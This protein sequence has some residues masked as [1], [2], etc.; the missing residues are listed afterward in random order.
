MGFLGRNGIS[1]TICKQSAPRSKQITTPTLHH[2]IFYKPDPL[3][4][5]HQQCQ[6]TEGI[7][8][9]TVE[10]NCLV[11]AANVQSASCSASWH[12][13]LRQ[14]VESAH[15]VNSTDANERPKNFNKR[16]HRPR[17]RHPRGGWVHSEAAYWLW[18][19]V[20]CGQ[21]CSP[22]PLRRF[23]LTQSNALRW[24]NNPQIVP[25]PGGNPGRHLMHG[26]L[27]PPESIFQTVSRSLH[28]FCRVHSAHCC[29]QQ[30]DRHT[31][32]TLTTPHL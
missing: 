30:T 29:D 23:L 6:S 1:W 17:T 5:A 2:S 19:A 8:I 32:N 16:P 12:P 13:R 28:S 31:D 15:A 26:S 18:C 27:G 22:V 21:V 20:P 9:L 24:E 4:G 14:S 3:S 25:F 10:K 11:L 7:S